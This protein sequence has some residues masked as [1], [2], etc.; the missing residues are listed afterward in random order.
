MHL[1][2][3]LG[4]VCVDLFVCA[5]AFERARARVPVRESVVSSHRRAASRSGRARHFHLPHKRPRLPPR[6]HYP[7]H[8]AAGRSSNKSRAAPRRPASRLH[9]RSFHLPRRPASVAPG[10]AR[11]SGRERA[12]VRPKRRIERKKRGQ[13]R[14][15]VP[16]VPDPPRPH[17]PPAVSLN[18]SHPSSEM[19]PSRQ[20][21]TPLRIRPPPPPCPSAFPQSFPLP[22]HTCPSP[23]RPAV[24]A[25]LAPHP[26]A[27]PPRRTSGRPLYIPTRT[28]AAR[29]GAHPTRT[30]P[31][32]PPAQAKT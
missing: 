6:T 12:S 18:P 20:H 14:S 17:T 27:A 11:P 15:P 26:R 24:S 30:R 21:T 32:A 16:G 10:Q 25:L 5:R 9:H 31:A 7:T 29:D 13:A 2:A 8:P 22:R 23:T 4:F 19:T 28:P 1:R 3:C